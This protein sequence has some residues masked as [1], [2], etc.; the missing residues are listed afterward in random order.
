VQEEIRRLAVA[1]FSYK[2]FASNRLEFR[3]MAIKEKID[4]TA[5]AVPGRSGKN[6][7]FIP[8]NYMEIRARWPI[9]EA[10]ASDR[11]NCSLG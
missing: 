6:R 7:R 9:P 1:V 4:G 2:A 10:Q 5:A 11:E 3:Q 8:H